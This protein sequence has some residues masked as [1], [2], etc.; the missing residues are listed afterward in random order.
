MD[1]FRYCLQRWL[2]LIYYTLTTATL[3]LF[4]IQSPKRNLENV[5]Q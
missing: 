4:T 1:K 5:I 2:F 3:L